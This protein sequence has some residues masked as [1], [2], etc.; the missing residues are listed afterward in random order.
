MKAFSYL[1]RWGGAVVFAFLMV[2]L[3]FTY[4]LQVESFRGKGMAP[5]LKSND[6]LVVW[7]M[8]KVKRLSV[9]AFDAQSE[10]PGSKVHSTFVKRVIGMPGDRIVSRNGQIY[11]NGKKL[12]QSFLSASQRE[13]TGNWTLKSLGRQNGTSSTVVPKGKYFVLSDDRSTTHAEDSR[14]W[15]YV[16]AKKVVGVAKLVFWSGSSEQRQRINQLAN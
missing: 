4:V 10:V 9:I 2:F 3:I 1:W 11:V 13:Q 14:D 7:R 5:N 16:S 12:D 15:G 8:A 6:S